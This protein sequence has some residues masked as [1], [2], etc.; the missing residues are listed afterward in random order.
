MNPRLIVISG[1]LEGHI[2]PLCGERLTIGRRV[3]N[4]LQLASLEVSRHH[5][6]VRRDEDRHFSVVDLE[7]RHGVFV[8]NRPVRTRRLAHSDLLT[9]GSSVLLFLLDD[10]SASAAA[11]PGTP[12]PSFVAG[13]TVAMKPSEILYFDRAR[14]DATLPAKAR[15]A[16]DLHTLL[17]ASTALQ[18]ARTLE[19]VAEDLLT[20]ALEALPAE[21][22][23]VLWHEVGVEEMTILAVHT[24][25]GA[26]GTDNDLVLSPTVLEQV[27]RQKVGLFCEGVPGAHVSTAGVSSLLCVPLLDQDGT[28]LGVV[29]GD[30]RTAGAF[31]KQHLEL[32]AALAGVASLAF[33]NALHLRWLEG[34]NRR[35]REH[36]LEHD[37][38]GESAPMQKLLHLITRVA[39]ADSTVLIRGESGTGKELVAQAIHRSSPRAE[40]AFVAVNCATLSET[41]LESELFGHEKGAFT[42]AVERKI[43]K[44]DAAQGGT[45]FLDEV[46]EIPPTLQARLLRVLQ[47]REFQRVGG[48]RSIRADVRVVAATNRDLEA[49][50]RGG[51]L[52]QDLYY[53]LKVITLETPPLRTRR[54]DIPLLASH[55]VALHSRRLG[56]RGVAVSQAARRCLMAYP[57]PGNVRELGNAIERALVLG[58][59]DVVRPE[60]LPDEV[61]E[62]AESKTLP[63][64][65][66]AALVAF[67]KKLVL[68]AWQKSGSDYGAT[69]D[70]LGIHVNSLHRMISRLGIR[71]QLEA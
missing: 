39:Q 33:R 49:A 55:F 65:F 71:D 56:R 66:Q 6:E 37:M 26:A 41:L 40:K 59:T 18:G 34:E 20:H 57:W 14:L 28:V 69:A 23:A 54:D 43:G 47:E 70:L 3:D 15:I 27:S 24:Q 25:G 7:S 11:I 21:R 46:G 68:D 22:A 13:S 9:V 38:V 62:G 2:V 50:I 60:D 12:S 4:D 64:D 30:S 63:S 61:L 10:S 17:R 36:Q 29:Y 35:L 53:R 42:G 67:K 8:N 19:Q 44:L 48:T 31:D 51:S 5:C 16:R 32:L 52:R 58:E 1:P 45:L